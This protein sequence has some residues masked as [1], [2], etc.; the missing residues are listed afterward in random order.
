[1]SGKFQDK[2]TALKQTIAMS[3]LK[4]N[5]NAEQNCT[6]HTYSNVQIKIDEGTNSKMTRNDLCIQQPIIIQKKNV[7][8]SKPSSARK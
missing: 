2:L 5:E 1:M 8:Q 3:E 4:N 6:G 7:P